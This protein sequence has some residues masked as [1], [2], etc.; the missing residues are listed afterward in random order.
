VSVEQQP[1]ATAGKTEGRSARD[2]AQDKA[3]ERELA[4]DEMRELEAGDAPTEREGWP[5]G[6]AQYLTYGSDDDQYGTGVTAK[7][8]PADVRHYADGS[9]SVGGEIVDDPGRYK[10]E[11]LI[12]G[13]TDPATPH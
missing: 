12:G 3:G 1:Q 2:K 11:P 6:P 5:S 8:G 13:P 9:V 10:G 7:L 4:Q